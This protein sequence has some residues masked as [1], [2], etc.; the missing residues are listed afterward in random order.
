MPTH[1]TTVTRAQ[2]VAEARA[3]IGTPY[4]HG[5]LVKGRAGGVDCAMLMAGVYCNVGYLPPFDVAH[6]PPDWFLNHRAERYLAVVLEH[7]REIAEAEAGP[8]DVAL[9]C[10]GKDRARYAHG[11]IVDADGLPNIIHANS[12]AGVVMPDIAGNGKLRDMPRRY[13]SIW[14]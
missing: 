3:W 11:A 10:L 9:F 13:F 1:P 8:G 5:Q 7:S 14:D 12:A 6:Y 2:V 4:H